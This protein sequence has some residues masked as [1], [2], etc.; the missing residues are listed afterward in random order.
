MSGTY[1]S[2]LMALLPILVEAAETFSDVDCSLTV[3]NCTV[4]SMEDGTEGE[5]QAVVLMERASGRRVTMG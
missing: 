5:A 1:H 3:I 4:S 2:R